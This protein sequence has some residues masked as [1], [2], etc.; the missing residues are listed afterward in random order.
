[1][2]SQENALMALMKSLATWIG[3][4]RPTREQL[5]AASGSLTNPAT[6]VVAPEGF[7]PVAG[8]DA[9]R[10]LEVLEREL[11]EKYHT[12]LQEAGHVNIAYPHKDRRLF[13]FHK[14]NADFFVEDLVEALTRVAPDIAWRR[15][16]ALTELVHL[17]RSGNQK[18]DRAMGDGQVYAWNPEAK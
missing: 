11:R 2:R 3:V 7:P 12:S 9:R 6:R 10:L 8:F 16:D 18:C 13:P 17:D 14:N 15:M 1:M 5:L 4:N